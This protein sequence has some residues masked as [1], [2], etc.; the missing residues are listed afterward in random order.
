M[1]DTA[2]LKKLKTWGCGLIPVTDALEALLE[3]KMINSRW[4]SSLSANSPVLLASVLGGGRGLAS[5]LRTVA[6]AGLRGRLL[7][8][9]LPSGNWLPAG[10]GFSLE[11]VVP[12]WVLGPPASS[13]L[14]L[15]DLPPSVS[16]RSYGLGWGGL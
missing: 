6:S 12:G 3:G 1:S 15:C 9:H 10:H 8:P 14:I 7:A 4:N 5:A 16:L 13:N 2:R 11:Q